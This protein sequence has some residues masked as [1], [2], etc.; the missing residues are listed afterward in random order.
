MK[1][2]FNTF[3]VPLSRTLDLGHRDTS[4]MERDRHRDNGRSSALERLVS[5]QSNGTM[6]GMAA[7]L[8]CRTIVPFL[9]AA[10]DKAE[11]K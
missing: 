2:P 11:A 4:E 10:W 3:D 9:H 5:L 7:G 8:Q 6:T 1:G